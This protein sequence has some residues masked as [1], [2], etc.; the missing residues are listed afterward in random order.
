MLYSRIWVEVIAGWPSLVIAA[1]QRGA[2]STPSTRVPTRS[3]IM[4]AITPQRI[5]RAA[6]I[7]PILPPFL[8]GGCGSIAMHQILCNEKLWAVEGWAEERQGRYAAG[9]LRFFG[10]GTM[11]SSSTTAMVSPGSLPMAR[12]ISDL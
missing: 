3:P 12:R 9:L 4:P 11:R 5:Q 6:L 8:L 2:S 1:F 10:G 7:F